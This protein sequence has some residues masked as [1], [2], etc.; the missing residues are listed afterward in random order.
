[1]DKIRETPQE[2][3][4]RSQCLCC[5]CDFRAET[6]AAS[7]GKGT[8]KETEARLVVAVN[9]ELRLPTPGMRVRND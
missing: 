3:K 6:E 7:G 5:G 4:A 1:M 2:S 8:A 9:D